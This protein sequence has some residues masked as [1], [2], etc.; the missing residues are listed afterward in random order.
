MLIK[1][2]SIAIC[3]LTCIGATTNYKINPSYYASEDLFLTMDK[4]HTV[5]HCRKVLLKDINL[6]NNGTWVEIE[7][8]VQISEGFDFAN[9]TSHYLNGR[10]TF[11]TQNGLPMHHVIIHPRSTVTLRGYDKTQRLPVEQFQW[12]GDKCGS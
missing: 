5:P 10:F 11:Q 2:L 1:N 4:N 3:Y 8:T 9:D 6:L 7:G 12:N